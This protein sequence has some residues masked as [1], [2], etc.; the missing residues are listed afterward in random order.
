MNDNQKLIVKPANT[1]YEE[2]EYVYSMKRQP[3]G[4]CMII[5]NY[6][7]NNEQIFSYRAGSIIDRQSLEFVFKQLGFE[8]IA[9]ENL[10]AHDMKLKCFELSKDKKMKEHDGL[11]VI[12]LSHGDNG[13]INGVDGKSVEIEDLLEYFNTDE[14]DYLAGKPKMFFVSACRGSKSE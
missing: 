14:C 4:Y 11:V 8:V 5:N 9:H 6:K 3:R 12:L 7:G 2:S 1:F 13:K 10:N